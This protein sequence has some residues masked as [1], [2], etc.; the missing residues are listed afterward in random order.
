MST[1]SKFPLGQLLIEKGVITQEQLD[2][3]LQKQK[4]TGEMLGIIL[5][6]LGFV[7]EEAVFLPVVAGQYGVDYVGLKNTEIPKEVIAKIPAKFAM[8]YKVVP[9]EVGEDSLI[10]AMGNPNDIHVLDELCLVDV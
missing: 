10:V 7:N 6:E 1:Q 8:H 3:A 2:I 5:L 9:V 4:E